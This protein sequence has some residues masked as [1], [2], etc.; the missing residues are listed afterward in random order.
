MADFSDRHAI[1]Y[2]IHHIVEHIS[3]EYLPMKNTAS[4]RTK[5]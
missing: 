4:P 2:R 5:E 1:R 3:N